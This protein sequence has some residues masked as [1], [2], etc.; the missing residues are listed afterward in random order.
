MS[1]LAGTPYSSLRLCRKLAL[2]Y[3][4]AATYSA[5]RLCRF[6]QRSSHFFHPSLRRE[7]ASESRCSRWPRV[8]RSS[9]DKRRA[10]QMCG[11]GGSSIR[12]KH[13]V[14]TSDTEDL[15]NL[16]PQKTHPQLLLR[17]D[18]GIRWNKDSR[19]GVKKSQ[20]A[21]IRIVLST[22]SGAKVILPDGFT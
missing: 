18:M 16:H 19:P 2:S 22:N 13:D 5:L 7:P 17:I 20:G 11:E 15:K 10:P 6:L 14:T 1:Y 8:C 3:L 4:A 9:R 21:A 12:Q